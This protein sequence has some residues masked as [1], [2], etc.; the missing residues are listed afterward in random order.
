[1]IALI[2]GIVLKRQDI[3]EKYRKQTY[4]FVD[5]FQNYVTD[6]IE[7]ILAESRKYALHLTLSHQLIGQKMNTKMKDIILGNTA[8]KVVGESGHKTMGTI[9]RE[10]GLKTAEFHQLPEYHFFVHNKFRRRKKLYL[11]QSSSFMLG[12]KGFFYLCLLYT[13]PSPRDR[14]RSRMP[15]SA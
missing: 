10:I 1:M 8:L 6:S 4:L 11:F 3:Q 7:D 15:S 13:S 5:E 2:Q 14:T 9:G 12:N